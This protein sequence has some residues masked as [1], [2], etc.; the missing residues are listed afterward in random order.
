MLCAAP[1]WLWLLSLP[2]APVARAH[3]RT[4]TR[5]RTPSGGLLPRGAGSFSHRLGSRPLPF[6]NLSLTC[7]V[8]PVLLLQ[9]YKDKYEN[10]ASD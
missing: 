4:R 5:T 3:T 9:N 1:H 10:A 6:L 7:K 8:L 2:P